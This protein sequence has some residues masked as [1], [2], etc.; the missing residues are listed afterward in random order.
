LSAALE[1]PAGVFAALERLRDVS[2]LALAAIERDDVAA[3]ESC[4]FE[5]ESLLRA[6]ASV[7]TDDLDD[8]EAGDL[9]DDVRRMNARIVESVRAERDRAAKELVALGATRSRLAASRRD[10]ADEDVDGLDYDA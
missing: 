10:D 9:L 1:R 6:L 7:S 8:P 4:A 3:L 2:R 5:T